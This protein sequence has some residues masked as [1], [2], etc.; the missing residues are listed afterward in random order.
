MHIAQPRDRMEVR[1]VLRIGHRI[2]E[3]Q[4]KV[5]LIVSNARGDL[6]LATLHARKALVYFQSGRFFD[7]FSRRAGCADI[8]FCQ[9]AAIRHAELYHQFLFAV[10]RD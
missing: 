9:D 4:D 7:E 3:E 8:M 2:A 1:L 10:V 5:D 6:L